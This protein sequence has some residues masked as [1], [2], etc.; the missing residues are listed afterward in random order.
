MTRTDI[1]WLVGP[2]LI[3]LTVSETTKHSFGEVAA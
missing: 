1:A 2:T 3:V